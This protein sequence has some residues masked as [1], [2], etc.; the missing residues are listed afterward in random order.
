M[1]VYQTILNNS[2]AE[3]AVHIRLSQEINED[4]L[5]KERIISFGEKFDIFPSNVKTVALEALEEI[6]SDEGY[7][8][9]C[10]AILYFMKNSLPL[11]CLMPPFEDGIK[12]EFAIFFPVWYMAQEN[13]EDME[14]RG[15]PKDII[16]KSFAG[17][18]SCVEANKTFKGCIGTS[19][20]FFWLPFHAHGKLF[21]IND[22]QYE[23]KEFNGNPAIGIHIPSGTKLDVCQN[24]LS[25][26]GALDFFAKYYPELKISGFVCESW[27]LSKE[28]EEVMGRKTNI[29]RFGDMFDRY[30][31]GD[32]KGDAVYR[33]V[34]KLTPPYPELDDLPED[35][36]LRKNL[37][38]YMKT[39]KRVY[40]CGG[41]I[42]T[43]KLHDML[44]NY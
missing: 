30:D 32:T 23:K 10:K 11:N 16:S 37:K 13:A 41:F 33:F 38:E 35:T 9:L 1:N 26:K 3:M 40:A 42:T 31:I 4:C 22:F 27:L 5:D 36:T 7:T 29:S 15:V 44:R 6:K 25:F 39:G 14:H 43:E 12:A 19:A 21:M 20:Y 8:V 28:I 18:C 24:L 34:Y 2:D 17:I